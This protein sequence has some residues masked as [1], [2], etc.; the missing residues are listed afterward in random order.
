M[1]LG[2]VDGICG[3]HPLRFIIIGAPSVQIPGKTRKVAAR[4]LY[5]YPVALFKIVAGGHGGHFHL[6]DLTYL[7]EHFPIITLTIAHPLYG[8]IQVIGAPIRITID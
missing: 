1:V 3:H 8:L 2:M 7:H 6:I 4:D 5:A